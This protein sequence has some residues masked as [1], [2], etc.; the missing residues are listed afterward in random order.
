MKKVILHIGVHKTGTTSIQSALKHYEKE[1]VKVASFREE[2]HSIP[3]YTIFSE[4]R[5]DYHIWKFLNATR[6]DIDQKK[7]H[8]LQALERD[9]K[10]KSL[11]TLI[12]SGEDM[13]ALAANE[14]VTL[15]EF[16]H[17]FGWHSEV[18]AY[19]RSPLSWLTSNTQQM[20]KNGMQVPKSHPF[21]KGRLQNYVNAFGLNRISVFDFD[22]AVSQDKSIVTHFSKILSLDLVEPP[23]QNESLNDLEFALIKSL[24]DVQ[25]ETLSMQRRRQIVNHIRERASKRDP[26]TSKLNQSYFASLFRENVAEECEWI[27][28]N[29]GMRYEFQS[30]QRHLKLQHYVEEILS[31]ALDEIKDIFASMGV[32][33][34]LSKSLHD[35]F[36]QA[37]IALETNNRDFCSQTYLERN[38]DVRAA[39]VHPLKHYLDYGFKAGRKAS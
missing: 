7:R 2:N 6:R 11:H 29:F 37:Y 26:K 32:S 8:Y 17:S 13:S 33:Y 1:G 19:A 5:Y 22:E 36:L 4:N 14:V 9:L 24:N 21:I 16:I 38:P 27:N 28:K 25:F 35:N 39:R 20:V 15:S 10:N 12:I 34:R 31:G 18:I 30:D 3:M 23:R